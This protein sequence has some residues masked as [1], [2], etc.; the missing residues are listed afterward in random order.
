NGLV[1]DLRPRANEVFRHT[2]TILANMEPIP[3]SINTQV[4]ALGDKAG[5]IL[6]GINGQIFGDVDTLIKK[7]VDIGEEYRQTGHKLNI[8]VDSPYLAYTLQQSALTTHNLKLI[9]GSLANIADRA[10]KKFASMLAPPKGV[11][12]HVKYG[13]QILKD[14]GGVAFVLIRVIN[15][16]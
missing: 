7:L 4:N 13:L 9:S 8:L 14:V 3:T 1:S 10:D 12:G 6:D 5:K 2:N 11:W 16:L 15:G